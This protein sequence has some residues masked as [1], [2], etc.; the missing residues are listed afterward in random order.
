MPD[1]TI[2]IPAP[3]ARPG[4]RVEVMRVAGTDDT[5]QRATLYARVWYAEEERWTY[6]TSWGWFSADRIRRAEG[7]S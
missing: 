1:A 7:N 3:I 4:D 2:T 6:Q 5:W